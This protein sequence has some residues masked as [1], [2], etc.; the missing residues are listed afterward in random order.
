[1]TRAVFPSTTHSTV[2]SGP[3][4]SRFRTSDG[5]DTCPRFETL[6]LMA[7]TIQEYSDV[8]K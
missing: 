4:E 7:S 6:V 2:V 5:T 8:Y 3:M 1:M